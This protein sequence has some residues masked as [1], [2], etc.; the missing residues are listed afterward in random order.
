[1]SR[2]KCLITAAAAAISLAIGSAPRVA[3]AAAPHHK[4]WADIHVLFLIWSYESNPFFGPVL[5]GEQAAAR[6]TGITVDVKYGD[7]KMSRMKNIEE[8]AIANGDNGLVVEIPNDNAFKKILCTAEHKDHIP[9]V[10]FNIDDSHHGAPGSTCR[11]AFVGQNFVKAGYALGMYMIK[12]FH[13]GKGDL[14]FTPVEVPS[15]VYAVQRHE[16]VAKALATVG[17]RTEIL[18]TGDNH[19][20]AL[21]LMTQFLLGHPNTKAI[22][23]LGQTPTSQAVRAMKDAG[24]KVPAGG[25]DISPG[26]IKDVQNGTLAA[27]ADQQPYTQGFYS[28]AQMADLLKY[29]LLPS[30]MATGG[31]ITKNNV[32]LAAKWAGITR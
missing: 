12:N 24:V 13:I 23:T 10:S 27:V 19:A 4:P 31:L 21:S 8:T 7:E 5:R 16:G 30:S 29:G 32:G 26:I 25:F 2:L 18:G 11:M 1:M 17:A 22:I 20:K 9:V 6:D 15:A 3:V 28:V 14:V